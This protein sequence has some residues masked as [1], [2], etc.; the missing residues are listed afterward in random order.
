MYFQLQHVAC[1]LS[2]GD[3][4]SFALSSSFHGGGGIIMASVTVLHWSLSCCL[5]FN[6]NAALVSV[7]NLLFIVSAAS[8]ANS[9]LQTLRRMTVVKNP[10]WQNW[11]Q[12]CKLYDRFAACAQA[13][14][15][16][17]LRNVDCSRLF[18]GNFNKGFA[19][20]RTAQRIS[21]KRQQ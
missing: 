20:F 21:R 1:P 18:Q 14:F 12:D 13:P 15:H 4:Q 11:Q 5:N 8:D 3:F 9:L 17:H 7:N 10:R 6:V 16:L 19:V 2:Q